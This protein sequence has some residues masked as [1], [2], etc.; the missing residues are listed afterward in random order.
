MTSASGWWALTARYC[1][2]IGVLPASSRSI[3]GPGCASDAA[4]VG[5]PPLAPPGHAAAVTVSI[6][7]C[8]WV[9]ARTRPLRSSPVGAV[10]AGNHATLPC[11]VRP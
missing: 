2:R 3:T 4:L 8:Q 7:S 6:S 11:R 5:R 9:T 10:P 1:W